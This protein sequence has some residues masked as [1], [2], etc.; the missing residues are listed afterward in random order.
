MAGLG[1][2]SG[3]LISSLTTKYRD[4]TFLVAFGVQLLMYGSSV[5]IP[6]SEIANPRIRIFILLNPLTSIIES[7][8]FIFLGT[9]YFS[10]A[11]LLYSFVFMILSVVVSTLIF[12]KVEKSFMDTV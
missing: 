1:F 3:I 11:W 4:L 7:F 8:K 5:I 12:N 10:Y 2:G 9:G 6:V